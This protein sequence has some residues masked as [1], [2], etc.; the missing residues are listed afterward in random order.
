MSGRRKSDWDKLERRDWEL[1]FLA[2]AMIFILAVGILM[3]ALPSVVADPSSLG[4]TLRRVLVGF[5]V[6][7][8]LFNAYLIERQLAIKAL[9]RKL[10]EE[11]ARIALLQL[12]ASEN[13]LLSLPREEQFRDRLAMELKRAEH[14]GAPLSVLTTKIAVG[15]S[16]EPSEKVQVIGEAVKL[17]MNSL[18]KEDSLY[19]YDENLYCVV[20]PGASLEVAQKVSA[21]LLR[22]FDT[23]PDLQQR[24]ISLKTYLTN[25]P[26]DTGSAY[27]LEQLAVQ[28]FLG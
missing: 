6:L 8:A 13:I 11:Q 2:V 14:S 22:I 19:Q 28:A 15:N 16:V 18:R 21:R 7:T 20:L 10:Y 17:I 26:K 12:Q 24:D 27:E 23:H 5:C 25:Y 9:R 1:W 3:A 4:M